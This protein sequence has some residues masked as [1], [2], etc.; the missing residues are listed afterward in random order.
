MLSLFTELCTAES[1]GPAQEGEG[2]R[3]LTSSDEEGRELVGELR[4]ITG[5]EEVII[6]QVQHRSKLPIC[7]A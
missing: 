4:T 2:V 5:G 7:H 6:V 1:S 3:V